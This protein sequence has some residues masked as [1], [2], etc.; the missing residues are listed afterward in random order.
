MY[1]AEIEN[2]TVHNFVNL[3]RSTLWSMYKAEKKNV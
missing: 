2:L 1:K 3:T